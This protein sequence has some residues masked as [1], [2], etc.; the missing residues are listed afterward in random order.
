MFVDL[1]LFNTKVLDNS[2]LI[3]W[4]FITYQFQ[5]SNAIKNRFRF[6]LV[7]NI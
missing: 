7:F 1:C 2:G 3:C 6:L 4:L 5:W